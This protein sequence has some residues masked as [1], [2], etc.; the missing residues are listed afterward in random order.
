S[1]ISPSIQADTPPVAVDDAYATTEDQPLVV[2]APGVRGNDTAAAGNP[3]LA[4][5]AA[6]PTNGS[7]TL[8][9]NGSFVYT[10]N[11]HFSGSDQFTYRVSDGTLASNVATVTLT[12]NPNVAPTLDAIAT[13]SAILENGGPQTVNLTGIAAGG[14][15]I[16]ALTV[17]A[18]SSNPALIP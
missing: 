2:S 12:V 5:L 14:G 6:P 7:V 18:T 15:A 17:T 9:A 3:L 1:E 10:P 13:P 8:N 16:Q 4:S 11:A